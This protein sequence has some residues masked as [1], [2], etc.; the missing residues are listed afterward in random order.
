MKRII[1]TNSFP[2]NSKLHFY[3][4]TIDYCDSFGTSYTGETKIE[5]ITYKIFSM[6]SWAD[7]LLKIRDFIVKPFGLY[8]SDQMFEKNKNVT[9]QLEKKLPFPLIEFSETEIIMHEK[10]KHLNF[11]VSVMMSENMV[12]LTTVV[13]YNN[14]WGK[15]YFAFVKPF[16]S[17]IIRS[18]VKKLN[19]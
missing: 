10:D 18:T 8:T 7:G 1:K 19:L 14:V 3:C 5:D 6:P 16:H 15:I 9:T 2:S 11:W 12:Y 13:E 4:K 17:L